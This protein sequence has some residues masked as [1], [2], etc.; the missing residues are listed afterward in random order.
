MAIFFPDNS[1]D[2]RK[3]YG[4][5]FHIDCKDYVKTFK[6]MS[7]CKSIGYQVFRMNSRCKC[8]CHDMK[9]STVLPFFKWRTNGTTRSLPKTRSPRLYHIVGTLSLPSK[10]DSVETTVDSTLPDYAVRTSTSSSER[11][12]NNNSD[13]SGKTGSYSNDMETERT[14]GQDN[15][16]IA[17]AAA[18]T[19]TTVAK[20]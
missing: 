5:S 15:S 3:H 8:S 7:A 2:S 14:S 13:T 9:T 18:P 11:E 12:R 6:C 16:D 19:E 10:I 20:A 17:T 1:N 4:L